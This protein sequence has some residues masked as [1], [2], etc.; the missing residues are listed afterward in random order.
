MNEL[1]HKLTLKY[2]ISIN[3]LSKLT[4]ITT[5][6]M[7]KYAKNHQGDASNELLLRLLLNP[8]N[9]YYIYNINKHKIDKIN[10]MKIE[11]NL[12]FK[13]AEM[14]LTEIKTIII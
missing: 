12:K 8:T 3:V 10:C 9:F 1:I 14:K 6:T 5:V 4:N 11:D 2:G 7:Y 13:L